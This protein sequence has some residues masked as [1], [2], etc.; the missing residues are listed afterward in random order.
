[1]LIRIM[2]NCT[3]VWALVS[4][5]ATPTPVCPVWHTAKEAKKYAKEHCWS[6]K[7][8]KNC[9]DVIF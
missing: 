6:V 9:D 7:R 1:M 8:E 3:P 2:Y 5:D 4:A